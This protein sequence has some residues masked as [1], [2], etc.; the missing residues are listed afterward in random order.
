M[1]RT[2]QRHINLISESED[3]KIAK[4]G[5]GG[6]FPNWLKKRIARLEAEKNQK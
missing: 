5:H 3:R 1:K 6:S 4:T 2:T